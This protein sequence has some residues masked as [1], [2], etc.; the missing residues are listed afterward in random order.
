MKTNCWQHNQLM[1]KMNYHSYNMNYKVN[2][3]NNKQ[4]IYNLKLI[5]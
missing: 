1:F 3:D 4:I 5:N 2:K